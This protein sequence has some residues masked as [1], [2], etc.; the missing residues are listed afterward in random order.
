MDMWYVDIQIRFFSDGVGSTRGSSG[1][2][3]QNFAA[4]RY[5]KAAGCFMEGGLVHGNWYY[6]SDQKL[7]KNNFFVKFLDSILLSEK[8]PWVFLLFGS[9]MRRVQ[10]SNSLGCY[11]FIEV[12]RCM[13]SKFHLDHVALHIFKG[14]PP[15]KIWQ[16]STTKLDRI[17]KVQVWRDTW[18]TK[19]QQ[20]QGFLWGGRWWF[21]G[22][23]WS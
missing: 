7:Q 6:R 15:F 10:A 20:L 2:L 4:F 14:Y 16:E 8:Q 5:E 13:N 18:Q 23:Q 12:C 19:H 21:A 3:P 1:K 11:F 9:H 22:D 17:Q